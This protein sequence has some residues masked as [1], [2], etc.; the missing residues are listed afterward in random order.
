MS[1]FMSQCEPSAWFVCI[2]QYVDGYYR[3]A[4]VKRNASDEIRFIKHGNFLNFY[5]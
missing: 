5:I 1:N 3:I 2:L 4:F